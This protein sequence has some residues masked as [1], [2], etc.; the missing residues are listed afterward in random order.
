MKKILTIILAAGLFAA[1]VHAAARYVRVNQVG[2]LANDQKLAV[3]FSNDNLSALTFSI[4]RVSDSA[5][6]FGPA[7]FPA[8]SGAYSPFAYT[9]KLDF[10]SFTTASATETYKVRLSDGTESYPF[11]VYDCVYS[12]TE[13]LIL[14][15]YLGQ[16][17]GADNKYA[18]AACHMYTGTTLKDGKV[19]GGPA[20]GTT[21]D[22]S[23]GWHDS[24]DYIKFMI[25]VGWSCESM[26]LAYRENP[27]AFQDNLN[28]HGAAGPNGIP[29]VL[30]E[31]K[32]ALDWIMKMNPDANTL[33]Y[34]VGGAEDHDSWPPVLPQYDNSNYTTKPYRPVYYGNGANTCGKAATCLAM[35]Y[36]IWN[37][38]GDT[39]YANTCRSH[40]IQIYAL[41]KANQRLQDANPSDFYAESD[42]HD[43]MEWAAAEL[44]RATGTSS[45]L[46]DAK[47]FAT[48]AGSAGGQL[49]WDACNF[50]AHYSLYTLVDSATQAT[51]K[52]YMKSDLTS[53]STTAAANPYGMCTGYSWGSMEILTGGIVKAQLWKKLF[54][55]NIYDG[56]AMAS[57]DYLLGKNPW[58]VCFIVGMGSNYPLDP[59][60]NIT[61]AKGIDIPG[62]PIEGPD[63]RSDW[64]SQGITL[65]AP[66]EYAAFQATTSSGGVYHDDVEDYATNECT[67][68]HA[69]LCVI[70]FANLSQM[71]PAGGTPTPTATSAAAT[72]TPTKTATRTSTI[73][74]TATATRTNTPSATPTYTVA[75]GT[76]TNTGTVSSTITSSPT[77][78]FTATA[79]PTNTFTDTITRTPTNTAT[80]TRTVTSTATRTY[81]FTS[82][83]TATETVTGIQPPTWTYTD[84][85]TVTATFTDTFTATPTATT[86]CSF[87][88]T[89]T[90]TGTTGGTW[91]YTNT[92]TSTITAT[93][94]RTFTATFTTTASPVNT[95]TNTRTFTP[96]YTPSFTAT[97]TP[98][99]TLTNTRTQT[100][101]PTAT[102]TRTPENDR[103]EFGNNRDVISFPNPSGDNDIQIKFALTKSA[104]KASVK[105]YTVA[106][107]K[108]DD[109]QIVQPL[110]AGDN[111]V[112]VRKEHVIGLAAGTYYYYVTV[113]DSAGKTA[114]SKNSVLIILR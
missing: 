54:G 92:P 69:G 29:D 104:L 22:A 33:Y 59:Q 44:Y 61:M 85:P 81:T 12:G 13:E 101:V 28:A 25:T 9:Y 112:T 75:T 97:T 46:T 40:A 98:T 14:N 16:R 86:T 111:V 89:V 35:A 57:R 32:Y 103:L 72:A 114:R 6:V 96:T 73:T 45:Y 20:D 15:F 38:L 79:T 5:V 77:A 27:T 100:T 84:T 30:D 106:G 88:A 56:V 63:S 8:T 26:L 91:T 68:T 113:E 39:T 107:R 50:L 76:P 36:Q 31:A 34:Q 10:S 53:N 11:K 64:N 17:C 110:S 105:M 42:W 66:D 7:S 43:D 87:T 82:T 41:G 49:D 95:F 2:F 70:M 74:N 93:F 51:L 94:T 83:S 23:G 71:C 102:P 90:P 80:L 65:G 62:M 3:A 58:G 78:S 37:A 60:H 55:E 24:G 108:I 21:I 1:N 99:A 52:N 67:T 47:S 109:V 4:V 19:V 18:G 48:A